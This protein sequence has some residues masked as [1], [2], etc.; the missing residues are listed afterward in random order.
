[1]PLGR[2]CSS[3]KISGGFGYVPTRS[4]VAA[5]TGADAASRTP[6]RPTRAASAWRAAITSG[7]IHRLWRRATQSR[8]SG[9]LPGSGARCSAGSHRGV[10][11]V[12]EQQGAGHVGGVVRGEKQ[13]A[14]G[15]FV[16][17]AVTPEQGALGGVVLVLLEGPADRF[18]ALL[19]KRRV[20]GPWA[21]R[22]HADAV[23]GV[24]R[25][26]PA[27]EPGD[28]RLRGVVLRGLAD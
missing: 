8:K 14:G 12:D 2:P 9:A 18:V 25:R 24:I 4:G 21:D 22:V 10:A 5:S 1:M 7:L 26:H 16:G 20:D 11:A 27:R 13:N 6:T 23:R 28:R 19:V 3:R 15:D 17:R